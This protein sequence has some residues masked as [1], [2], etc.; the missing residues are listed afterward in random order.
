MAKRSATPLG[1]RG[2]CAAGSLLVLAAAVAAQPAPPSFQASPEVYKVVSE[3]DTYRVIE[4][5]WAAGHRDAPHSHPMAA[6]YFL[7]DCELRFFLPDGSTRD[8]KPKTGFSTVQ[9]AI[10]SHS[11]QNVG[12][13]PCKLVMFEPK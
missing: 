1:L 4:V 11:V 2:L 9:A 10:P 13:S 3:N 12:T 7:T 6:T 8:G 5:T